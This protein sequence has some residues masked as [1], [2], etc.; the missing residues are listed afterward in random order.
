MII[1]VDV[2]IMFSV[3]SPQANRFFRGRRDFGETKVEE[4][5]S[6]CNHLAFIKQ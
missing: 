3:L 4:L 5:V 2:L 1:P 6:G